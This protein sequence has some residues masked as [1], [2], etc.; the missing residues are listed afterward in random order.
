ML[1][2]SKGVLETNL[3]GISHVSSSFPPTN[4]QR[5]FRDWTIRMSVRPSVRPS[6]LS[7]LINVNIVA[8]ASC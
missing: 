2:I 5:T 6:V 3:R 8:V 7:Y 1:R 4:F